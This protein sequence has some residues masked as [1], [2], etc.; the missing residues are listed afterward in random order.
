MSDL[1]SIGVHTA[2]AAKSAQRGM[3]AVFEIIQAS[4]QAGKHAKKLCCR[5]LSVEGVL[6]SIMGKKEG[7][8]F[9]NLRLSQAHIYLRMAILST[10]DTCGRFLNTFKEWTNHSSS[11]Y[12]HESDS[13]DFGISEKMESSLISERLHIF[14]YTQKYAL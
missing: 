4:G 3:L 8:Y 1:T 12:L 9:C 2:Q 10:H 11:R 13:G 5:L 6:E 7:A 14:K